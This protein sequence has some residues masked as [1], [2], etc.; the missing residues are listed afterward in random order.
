MDTISLSPVNSNFTSPTLLKYSSSSLSRSRTPE[1]S[2]HALD[3]YCDR[4]LVGKDYV[5]P[6]RLI[7]PDHNFA[8]DEQWLDGGSVIETAGFL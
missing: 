3:V 5:I 6:D 4:P 7:F 8:G 1:V 2:T